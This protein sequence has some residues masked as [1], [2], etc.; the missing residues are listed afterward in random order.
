M[1]QPLPRIIFQSLI[2]PVMVLMAVALAIIP[3][4]QPEEDKQQENGYPDALKQVH[5]EAFFDRGLRGRDVKIGILDFGFANLYKD[6]SV[7]HLVTNGQIV[8][9]VDYTHSDT[10]AFYNNV[11]GTNVLRYM[12]GIDP[13]DTLFGGSLATGARFYLAMVTSNFDKKSDDRVTEYLIDSALANLHSM[14]VRLINLSMG[15]WDEYSNE[16]QNYAANQMDGQTALITKVCQKWAMKGMIIVN[17]A[18]NTGEYAWKIIWAPS[19]APDVIAV[20]AARFP[21]KVFK[22]SYSGRGNPAMSYIKPELIAF[23]P[24]GTSFSAPVITGIV[25][26]MLQKDSTL[27]LQQI[28]NI[29][30]RSGTLYPFPNNF[31]GYGVPDAR[32]IIALMEHPEQD[33]SSAKR[34][35]VS[36]DKY[37]VRTSTPNN[38][39]FEKSDHYRVRRQ[40]IDEGS[41]GVVT[42][43]RRHNVKFTTVVTGETAYEIIWKSFK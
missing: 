42:V 39:V 22:A 17:S 16:D 30:I 25:A 23:T 1:K 13:K 27:T 19:D 24:W 7:H 38:V 40:Y 20:G 10:S 36:G 6:P 9:I 4:C 37:Q 8:L 14:G 12:A 5:A 3:G 26:C 35:E 21:D 43:R 31:V 28:R 41:D 33:L 15:F 18:G 29:L 2:L 11:H 32:K 34:V